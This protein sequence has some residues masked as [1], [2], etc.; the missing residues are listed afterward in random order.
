MVES[1]H[2]EQLGQTDSAQKSRLDQLSTHW[3]SLDEPRLF[4]VRYAPA[5]CSYFRALIKNEH[6]AEEVSQEFL[7]RAVKLGF[8]SARPERGRFRDY[9]KTAVRNAALT[10]LQRARPTKLE[11]PVQPL[12]TVADPPSASDHEW[13]AEWQGCILA[14]AWRALEDHQRRSPSNL[15]HTVLQLAVDYPEESS[16]AL[17]GRT[18]ELAGRPM[19]PMA[20]RKQLSRAR[21]L[22]AELLA[23][24]VWH[25][26]QNPTPEQLEEELIEI[27]LLEY[28]RDFLPADW[29]TRG[30]RIDPQ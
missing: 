11:D 29:R 4:L 5:I 25:T 12:S 21:H 3:G 28:V 23:L 10:Y 7:L 9:L 19:T 16:Q 2:T 27:G 22:F 13:L 1:Q 20:F 30:L 18:A 24:E 8:P 14:R 6:D 26:L 17:A 15:Y